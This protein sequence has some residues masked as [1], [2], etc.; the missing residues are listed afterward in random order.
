LS[1][2]VQSAIVP[3]TQSVS[4]V[5]GVHSYWLGSMARR[6]AACRA[7]TSWMPRRSLVAIAASNRSAPSSSRACSAIDF[8]VAVAT[9]GAVGSCVVAAWAGPAA[10]ADNATAAMAIGQARCLFMVLLQYAGGAA[11]WD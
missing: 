7:G 11:G 10:N 5:L 1:I 3:A 8:V 9:A 6:T 4:G 2:I